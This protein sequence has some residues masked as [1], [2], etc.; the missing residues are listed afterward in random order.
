MN[1]DAIQVFSSIP[2]E[3]FS[4]KA[5]VSVFTA[6]YSINKKISLG[7]NGEIIKKGGGQMGSGG[8]HEHSFTSMQELETGLKSLGKAQAVSW[9]RAL[10]GDKVHIL[11]DSE[12]KETQGDD[13]FPI[14]SMTAKN[15]YFNE[16]HSIFLLDYDAKKTPLK[17]D[18][19]LTQVLQ[20]TCGI[21]K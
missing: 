20:V 2:T 7:K 1:Q 15:F 5:Y 4:Y 19:L 17:S 8:L 3:K 16:G 14:I 13:G 11:K 10:Q 6:N 9:G 12:I 21:E 18:E